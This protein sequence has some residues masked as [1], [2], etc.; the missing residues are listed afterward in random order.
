MN[1]QQQQPVNSC[2]KCNGQVKW[3][4]SQSSGKP[5]QKCAS[6]NCKW[7][8]GDKSGGN[9][10]PPQAQPYPYQPP[11]QQPPPQQYPPMQM[12][13]APTFTAPQTFNNNNF[14]DA[15]D[16][17]SQPPQFGATTPA[18][19][20]AAPVP[21]RPRSSDD[22]IPESTGLLF[23]Q[24]YLESKAKQEAETAKVIDELR[25]GTIKMGE[26]LTSQMADLSDTLE[27]IQKQLTALSKHSS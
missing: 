18:P 14:D 10:Y 4:T 9:Q 17:N 23:L 15:P 6:R 13:G 11:Q 7:W 2:P 16:Q 26:A 5:Y 20:Y 3:Q 27:K 25:E 24:A 12:S 8:S 22:G 21:K 1:N 19:G